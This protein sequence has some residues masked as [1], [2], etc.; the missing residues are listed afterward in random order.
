MTVLPHVYKSKDHGE[1]AA[2][3]VTPDKGNPKLVYLTVQSILDPGITQTEGL[4]IQ[5]IRE[6]IKLSDI[7]KKAKIHKL[8][9]HIHFNV[10]TKRDESSNKEPS[11]MRISVKIKD[12]EKFL[13]MDEKH[14]RQAVK[15]ER[16]DALITNNLAIGLYSK[17]NDAHLLEG[18]EK[19]APDELEPTVPKGKG[20]K[21]DW[22][23][24]ESSEISDSE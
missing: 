4:T 20:P 9:N 12:L 7:N 8:T 19:K 3:W 13:Q 2:Y 6:D 18:N 16:F 5:T 21:K 14:I 24:D 17:E 1:E 15:D 11:Y 10:H 22:G 23:K